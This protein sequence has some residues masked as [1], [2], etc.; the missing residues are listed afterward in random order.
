[1]MTEKQR[2][3]LTKTVEE[4]GEF[5]AAAGKALAHGMESFHA[6]YDNVPNTILVSREAGDLCGMLD[7]L[8]RAG[9]LDIDELQTY[10]AKKEQR[11]LRYAHFQGPDKGNRS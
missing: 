3:L 4:A 8:C 7:M 10:R 11:F 1:M 5:I 9:M 6:D 2:E